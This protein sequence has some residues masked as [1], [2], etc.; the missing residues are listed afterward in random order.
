ML[1]RSV[2][3][4][5]FGILGPVEALAG[6]AA[7]VASLT[8]AG[9]RPGDAFPTGSP[10]LAASGATFATVVIAQTANAW[11]CRSPDVWP[12]ALG[13]ATNRLLVVGASVELALATSFLVVPPIAEAL[14]HRAPGAAGWAVAVASAPL[15]LA[16]DAAHKARRRRRALTS[17]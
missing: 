14:G 17:P 5:A 8:A 3:A 6:M 7:F 15:V 13:W 16:A 9:W 12:G 2:A 10:L 4:R 11:A 1:D